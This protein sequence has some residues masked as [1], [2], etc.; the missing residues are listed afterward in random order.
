M[1]SDIARKTRS[2]LCEGGPRTHDFLKPDMSVKE[3]VSGMAH[4]PAIFQEA[5]IPDSS[6]EEL[7]WPDVSWQ[8]PNFRTGHLAKTCTFLLS[9]QHSNLSLSTSADTAVWWA[10]SQMIFPISLLI[11]KN[12]WHAALWWVQRKDGLFFSTQSC[13]PIMDRRHQRAC[14]DWQNNP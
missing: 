11:L 7:S 10:E 1:G 5:W 4:L 9:L 2:S 14:H 3:L 12:P 8:S 13:F 6:L